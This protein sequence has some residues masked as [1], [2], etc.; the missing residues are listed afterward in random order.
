MHEQEGFFC[1]IGVI[2]NSRKNRP[3]E[4]KHYWAE[5]DHGPNRKQA[6]GEVTYPGPRPRSMESAGPRGL[7]LGLI[8]RPAGDPRA[9]RA[10]STHGRAL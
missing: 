3:E 8:G 1:K 6:R 9:R 10:Q 2:S 7:W 5:T 4:K